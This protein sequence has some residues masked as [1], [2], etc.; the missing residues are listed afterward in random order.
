[1]GRRKAS[2]P[3]AKPTGARRLIE[4]GKDLLIVA[5]TCLAV[6]LTWQT[7][8]T[9]QLRDLVGQPDQVAQPVSQQPGGAVTPY[10][11]TAR[12]SL[13]LYG[14]AYDK[15][16]VARAFEQL[17]PL[18]GEG[19]ATAGTGERITRRQWQ[20]L[21]EE[22][23][24]YCAFQGTPPLAVLSAWLGGE[25]SL[26]GQAQALLL[27]WDGSQVWLCW[28]EDARYFRAG[29]QVAYEGHM[30]SALESFSPNG[31]A[32]ASAMAQSDRAYIS[33]DP[34]VLVSMT[35]P[36]PQEY[37]AAAP[38]LV[39][40]PE[41]LEQLLGALGFQSGV[42]SAY[43][44]AGGLAINESGDR[45]R[46]SG[47]GT[48]LFHA[49]EE[50]RYRVAAAADR[51]TA[52]E[53]ATAAWELLNRAAA[54]WKGETDF[55]LTGAEETAEGWIVT[56]HGRL[57]GIPLSV[58]T[59]GWYAS[60]TVTDQMISDFT[61][62]LRSYTARGWATLLTQERL[63]AGAMN[64]PSMQGKG[65]RLTLCYSDAGSAVLVAGWVAEE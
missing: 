19:L 16:L 5:L 30:D 50:P 55:V 13:G 56:F 62:Q 15:E 58:G 11:L 53:A 25:G 46:V 26:E 7:P 24:I 34:D 61:V 12:N 39:R 17:S 1:M 54:P 37:A 14:A 8:L 9:T 64:S 45:L 35:A 59:E 4:L 10:V 32:F 23:G 21:L 57:R 48:V 29:T 20:K 28:R 33:V 41:A 43:E 2:P 65:R 38:D 42:G 36:Q 47:A 40:D 18:L 63:A 3:V 22:P 51:P 44:A 6:F 60:F 52:E 27:A 49:G 31:A